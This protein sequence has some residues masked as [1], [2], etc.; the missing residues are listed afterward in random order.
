MFAIVK[1]K[2]IKRGTTHA[3]VASYIETINPYV[4]RRIK[5]TYRVINKTLDPIKKALENDIEV[6]CIKRV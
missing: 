5:E 2:Y 3:K 4:N 1:V 6:V